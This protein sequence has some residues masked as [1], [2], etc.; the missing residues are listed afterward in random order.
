M[1]TTIKKATR[2]KS[3]LDKLLDNFSAKLEKASKGMT[4]RELR[5]REKKFN[6]TLD[7]AVAARKSRRETA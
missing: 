6:A 7:R 2:K 5:E 1:S 3:A 4:L